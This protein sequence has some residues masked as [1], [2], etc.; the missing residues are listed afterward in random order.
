MQTD[1]AR[2]TSQLFIIIFSFDP[3][4]SIFNHLIITINVFLLCYIFQFIII[5]NI[6]LFILLYVNIISLWGINLIYIYVTQPWK[7]FLSPLTKKSNN[8]I[9][10]VNIESNHPPSIIKQLLLSIKSR[11]SSL[12][13]SED[14]IND[15]VTPYQNAKSGNKKTTKMKHHLNQLIVQQKCKN[16][17][18]KTIS[19]SYKETLSI[20]S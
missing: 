15:S 10:Y 6:I 4:T 8:Q 11:L 12:S 5:I 20:S 1:E 17:H 16:K 18:R 7:F 3:L 14:I 13:S 2:I 9:Q 19:K